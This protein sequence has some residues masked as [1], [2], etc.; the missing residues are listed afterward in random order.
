ME[1]RIVIQK[2]NNFIIKYIY[3]ISYAKEGNQEKNKI[4][5][6]HRISLLSI[7]SR[8][9]GLRPVLQKPCVKNSHRPSYAIQ[10]GAYS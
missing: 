7:T 5:I 2:G 3:M 9:P 8:K 6:E 10:Y 4:F 1:Y